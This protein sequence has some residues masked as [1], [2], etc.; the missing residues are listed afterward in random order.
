MAQTIR[1]VVVQRLNRQGFSP[2]QTAAATM[3]MREKWDE[4]SRVLGMPFCVERT[5]IRWQG[6]NWRRAKRRGI[7]CKLPYF[8]SLEVTIKSYNG[9]HIESEYAEHKRKL[10]KLT[11]RRLTE[12]RIRDSNMYPFLMGLPVDNQP[13][14]VMGATSVLQLTSISSTTINVGTTKIRLTRILWPECQ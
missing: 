7:Q 1:A 6:I 14:T 9:K 12:Y 4:V 5:K 2:L 3:R 11:F 10:R 8:I 13:Y